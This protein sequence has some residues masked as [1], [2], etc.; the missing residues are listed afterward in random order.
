[1]KRALAVLALAAAIV[2]GAATPA[3]AAGAEAPRKDKICITIWL[4]TT[5]LITLPCIE[6]PV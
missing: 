1:M 4:G 5:K 2:G 6:W 3:A